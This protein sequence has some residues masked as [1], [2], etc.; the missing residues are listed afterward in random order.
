LASAAKVEGCEY[1]ANLNLIAAAPEL[2]AA[3]KMVFEDWVTLVGDD[4]RE[5]SEDVAGI[6]SLCESAIKKAEGRAE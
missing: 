2:L 4:L 6:W 1:E 5:N 3:L